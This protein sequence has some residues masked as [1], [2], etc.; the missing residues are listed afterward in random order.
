MEVPMQVKAIMKN[1]ECLLLSYRSFLVTVIVS[2]VIYEFYGDLL[3]K[4]I[5]F[6][7]RNIHYYRDKMY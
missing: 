6:S 7:K 1:A 3:I 2:D 5:L 4:L